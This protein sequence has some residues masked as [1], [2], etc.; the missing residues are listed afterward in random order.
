[1]FYNFKHS[2]HTFEWSKL[3]K[4]DRHNFTDCTIMILII[5]IRLTNMS[6]VWYFFINSNVYGILLV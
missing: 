2:L 6:Y 4:S 5:F 3:K 1:M